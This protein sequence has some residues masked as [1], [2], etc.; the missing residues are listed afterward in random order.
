M[1]T[2]RQTDRWT[3]RET[4]RNRI[5]ETQERAAIKEKEIRKS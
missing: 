4:G 1:H 3:N 5:N 2:D